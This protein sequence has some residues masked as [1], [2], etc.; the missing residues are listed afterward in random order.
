[1]TSKKEAAKVA[2]GYTTDKHNCGN[3]AHRR[4]DVELAVWMRDEPERYTLERNGIEVRQRCVLGGFAIK[5]AATCG[6][7]AAQD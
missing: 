7:W 2:Q 4:F 5:K 6:K 3:C 1:V